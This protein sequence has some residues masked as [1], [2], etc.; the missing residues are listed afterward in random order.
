[1]Q[2]DK[3]ITQWDHDLK[4]LKLINGSQLTM[5]SEVIRLQNHVPRSYFQ[6]YVTVNE[7]LLIAVL[8]RYM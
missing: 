4:Q 7:P 6:L 3:N 1:M 2:R 5:I 8:Y